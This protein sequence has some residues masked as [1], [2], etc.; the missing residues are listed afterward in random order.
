MAFLATELRPPRADGGERI[1]RLAAETGVEGIHLGADC[2]LEV[3][4][5]APLVGSALRLGLTVP[6]LTLPLAERVLPAGRRLPRL[7]AP[8]RD[9]REAAVAL[10]ARGLEI[11]ASFGAA[12]A[13]LDFGPVA[14]AAD[15]ALFAHAFA[16]RAAGPGEPGGVL[17]A[18]AVAERRA[19][20]PEILD[21][22]RFALER[23]LRAADRAGMRLAAQLGVTPWQS[24]SPRE[25]GVLYET[26]G[27]GLGVVWD[28]ARLSVLAV[29][30]LPVGDERLKALA[31][32]AAVILDNDA[33]GLGCGYLPGLG[34]RDGRF[35]DAP[36]PGGLPRV[37][38][39]GPDA[40]DAEVAVA[41][42]AVQTG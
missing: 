18:A 26:F 33:V 32:A 40:T 35:A 17:L 1:T 24:P 22:C 21:A 27:E 9:E 20:S 10:A 12:R 36:P 14:L 19:L 41:A 31:G 30:G 11:A 29:L 2:D 15:P 42:T 7:A 3:I 5:G 25:L 6:S 8:A 16:R 34:E 38:L 4:N 28:P 13:L 23:L 37:V 39:G